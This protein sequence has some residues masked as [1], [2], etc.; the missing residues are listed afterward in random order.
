MTTVAT[1]ATD[2]NRRTRIDVNVEGYR[3]GVTTI[4]ATTADALRRDAGRPEP[5]RLDVAGMVD[6]EF[7]TVTAFATASADGDRGVERDRNLGDDCRRSGERERVAAITAATADTLD[8]HGVRVDALGV[9]AAR[10]VDRDELAETAV[11][12]R[13]T[14]GNTDR[15]IRAHTDCRGAATIAATATDALR[16]DA[17]RVGTVGRK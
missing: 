6:V 12:T 1:A 3:R 10:V 11:T 15:E 9:D 5:Q 8:E 16:E 2:R 13:T 14:H 4:A 7:A 17:D